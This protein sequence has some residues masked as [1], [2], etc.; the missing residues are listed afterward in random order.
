MQLATLSPDALKDFGPSDMCDG[1][2]VDEMNLD[3][4]VTNSQKTRVQLARRAGLQYPK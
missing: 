2:C 1:A 3:I 4:R